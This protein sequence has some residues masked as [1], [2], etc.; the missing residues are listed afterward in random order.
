MKRLTGLIAGCALL[1]G[2]IAYA[3]PLPFVTGPSDPSQLQ[4]AINSLIAQ[5]NAN[6]GI[7]GPGHLQVGG[8]GSPVLTSC[9]TSPAIT[10]TDTAGVVTMGTATPTGC[11]LTF[12]AP[13]LSVP[14]CAVTWKTNLASMSYVVTATTLTLTQ[15]G[16]NSNPV[17]YLCV[18]Q[19]G[20]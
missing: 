17:M 6:I 5:Y 13:Y 4:N 19:P 20:G 18:G 7:W 1:A 16:T 9:G 14:F 8:T 15:T 3:A 10:G 11:V 12:A 2:A